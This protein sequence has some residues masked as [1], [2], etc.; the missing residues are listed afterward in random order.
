VVAGKLAIAATSSDGA[1]DSA[2]ASSA[3]AVA[4][5]DGSSVTETAVSV[6]VEP[7]AANTNMMANNN[8]NRFI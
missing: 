6:D 4:G 8:K 2:G 7:H 1:A 5:F 3:T